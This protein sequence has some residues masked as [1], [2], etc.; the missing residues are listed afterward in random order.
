MYTRN[1]TITNMAPSLILADSV[2]DPI[3]IEFI[4][5]KFLTL[6]ANGDRK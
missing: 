3:T 1:R 5:Y 4:K 6:Q 2:T